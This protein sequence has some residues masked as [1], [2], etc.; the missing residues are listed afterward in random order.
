VLEIGDALERVGW[1]PPLGPTELAAGVRPA[2]T[3]QALAR[4]PASTFFSLS[5][6]LQLRR[7]LRRALSRSM[8]LARRGSRRIAPDSETGSPRIRQLVPNIAIVFDRASWR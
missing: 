4:I 6:A 7:N 5:S 3:P 1:A 8:P 2:P